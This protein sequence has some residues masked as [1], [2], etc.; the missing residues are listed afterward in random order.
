MFNII[1][2]TKGR[3]GFVWSTDNVNIVYDGNSIGWGSGSSYSDSASTNGGQYG[4]YAVSQ[5]DFIK[6]AGIRAQGF[7]VPAR[8]IATMI[9]NIAQVRQIYSPRKFNLLI[10]DEITNEMT[11]QSTGSV[12]TRVTGV[13]ARILEYNNAARAGGQNWYIM[14]HAAIPRGV[15]A[16]FNDASYQNNKVLELVNQSLRDNPKLYGIDSLIDGCYIGSPFRQFTNYTQAEFDAVAKYYTRIERSS[17]NGGVYSFLADSVAGST[18]LVNIKPIT[19]D[20][21]GSQAIGST[22]T[23]SAITSGSLGIAANGVTIGRILLSGTANLVTA[24]QAQFNVTTPGLLNL[25]TH[26]SDLG[27]AV[28]FNEME[29]ELRNLGTRLLLQ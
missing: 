5:I 4:A 17:S 26:P 7:A 9:A 3:A 22:V 24:T 18:A 23:S 6:K 16:V 15:S 13:L 8:N 1:S 2:S 19:V 29:R 25:H 20:T 21:T 27:Y 10:V 12:A 28:R 14:W 11:T